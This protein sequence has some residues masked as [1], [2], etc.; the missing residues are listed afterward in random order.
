MSAVGV[1]SRIATRAFVPRAATPEEWRAYHRYLRLRAAE[2]SP[3]DPVLED[4]VR[5]RQLLTEWP[6][7]ETHRVLALI[8]GEIAGSLAM[9][10]RRKG[11]P[12][13]EAHA[14]FVGADA[15]VRRDCRRRG[16]A[17]VLLA[18]LAA[19][20]RAGGYV[21]ATMSARVGDGTAYLDTIGAAE[22]HRA[23]E[24]RLDLARADWAGLGRWE[25]V[26]DEGSDELSWEIHAGRVPLDRF[27]ELIPTLTAMVNS[28]PLGTLEIPPIRYE[29]EQIKAWYANM[30]A[31]GGDHVMALLRSGDDL[32]AV[33]EAN[34]AADYPDRAFQNLTAVAPEWRGKGLAKAAKAR[35]LRALRERRPEI[36]L[37][38]SVNAHVNAAILAINRQLGFVQHR[39]VRTYQ[40]GRD[41]IEAALAARSVP[42]DRI[43]H[44]V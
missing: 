16:V 8:E 33:S 10:A 5:Q 31:H 4:D 3:E 1:L 17:M 37:L 24:N 20:M 30:D 23:V 11:T 7:F 15:G 13:Y 14:P 25:A 6:L 41:G 19:F 28:Q 40:I 39:D 2:E 12:E 21:T 18:A 32:V 35:L 29:I 27:A 34:W 42:V 9:W 44:D 43:C 36:V 22:K 26:A 38:I